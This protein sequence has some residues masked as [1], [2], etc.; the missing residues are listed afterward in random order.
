MSKVLRICS[1]LN[2][3]Y[4]KKEYSPSQAP[5][6]SL[7]LTLLSQ[8]TSSSNCSRAFAQLRER[9]PLW[10][11]VLKSD[12]NDI[13]EAIRPGGL[14]EIK[15]PRIKAILQQ[16]YEA[17]GSLDLS[18]L[19]LKGSNEVRDYL[20]SFSGVGPKTAACVLLFSLGRPVLPVDTHVLRISKRLGLIDQKVSAEKA[21]QILQE[22]LPDDRIYS[23]HVNMIA[24]GRAVCA[25][26]APKCNICTL[27]EDC[28]YFA[29]LRAG[30]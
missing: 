21:H 27:K 15:A 18:W 24:H 25:A 2:A 19:E 28:D 26:G 9:F 17:Q 7:I 14:A 23:F 20:L 10:E 11:N 3:A 13:A 16:I 5:L 4:G 30:K 22:M 12:V 8:N 29:R 6:D 1:R